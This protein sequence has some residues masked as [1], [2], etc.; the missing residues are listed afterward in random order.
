[1]QIRCAECHE[2]PA[3]DNEDFKIIGV[4]DGAQPFDPGRGGITGNPEELGAFAVPTLRNAALSPPFMHSGVEQ[5]LNDVI[6]FYLNGGGDNLNIPRAALDENLESFN[7]NNQGLTDLEMFLL[8][9]TDESR[10]PE[11]PESLPSGLEPVQP[12]ENPVRAEVEAAAALPRGAPRTFEVALG[13][14]IQEA[15]DRAQPG[16]TV[17]VP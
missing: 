7:L 4:D 14:S 5:N 11:I 15:I 8:A 16:D 2:L 17:V 1:M 10:L 13:E 3:F 6:S 9:L 12:L